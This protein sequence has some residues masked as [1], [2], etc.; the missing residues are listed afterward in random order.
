MK[1][2]QLSDWQ[3]IIPYRKPTR[4]PHLNLPGFQKNSWSEELQGFPTEV[5]KSAKSALT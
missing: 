3:S 4:Y 5:P 1:K 2:T